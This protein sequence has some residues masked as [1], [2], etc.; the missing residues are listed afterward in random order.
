MGLGPLGGR[1]LWP[2]ST[3]AIELCCQSVRHSAGIPQPIIIPIIS[4]YN[5]SLLVKPPILVGKYHQ[6]SKCFARCGQD[7]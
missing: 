2:K 3:S 1:T 5:L 4:H 6:P 7:S